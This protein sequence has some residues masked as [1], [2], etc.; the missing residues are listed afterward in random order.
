MRIDAS[1]KPSVKET[2]KVELGPVFILPA[3]CQAGEL[4]RLPAR[5][6]VTLQ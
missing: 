5:L 4:V 6:L 3:S 2:C 1:I